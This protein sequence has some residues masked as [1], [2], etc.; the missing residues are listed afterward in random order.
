[1]VS[2]A[3]ARPLPSLLR[4]CRSLPGEL[5]ARFNQIDDIYATWIRLAAE[6]DAQTRDHASPDYLRIQGG[7][8]ELADQVIDQCLADSK[9]SF[10]QGVFADYG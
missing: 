8:Q 5:P 4:Y 7:H 3:D 9:D 6:E 1:M 2:F 10:L